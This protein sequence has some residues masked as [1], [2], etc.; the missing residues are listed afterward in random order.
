MKIGIFC[1]IF[2]R[3]Q[4]LRSFKY[5]FEKDSNKLHTFIIVSLINLKKFKF[6]CET[7]FCLDLRHRKKQQH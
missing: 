4:N 5:I 1:T 3:I 6:A 2:L 7:H